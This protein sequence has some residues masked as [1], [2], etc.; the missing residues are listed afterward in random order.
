[1]GDR[2]TAT[3]RV[4]PNPFANARYTVSATGLAN[5]PD[6]GPPEVAFAGRSNAG[7]SSAL[8]VLTERRG[9]ARVSKTP[10]RTQM[11]NFF[12][13]DG[14]RL[15]DLP[16]YGF[17]KVPERVRRSWGATIG[18]FLRARE[19]LAGVVI[20]MDARHPLTAFD[21][22]MLDW[23]VSA[24]IPALL[25]MTKADKLSRGKGAAQLQAVRREVRELPQVHAQLFSALK[26]DGVA[27][28]RQHI[29]GWL[30]V[31][32]EHGASPPP[33]SG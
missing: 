5:L 7:K 27:E 10:G 24:G 14:L 33:A 3:P 11:L 31:V 4:M 32:P 18:N 30:P 20:V 2:E 13:C 22:Q 29:I 9:L 17:A 1:M 12:D 28:A 15:V 21:R 19:S 6:P 8:N 23:T 25:L 26:R 16:G